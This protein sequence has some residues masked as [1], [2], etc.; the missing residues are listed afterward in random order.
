MK[1][2]PAL[3]LAASLLSLLLTTPAL[4][5]DTAQPAWDQLPA[6]DRELLLQPVRE[7]WN[8][9]DAAQRARML[10]HARRWRDMPP[11]QRARAHVGMRRFDKLTP[12]Q[13]AQMKVLFDKTRGMDRRERRQ[14][15]ALFHAM[16]GMSVQQRD[17][18]RAQWSKMSSQQR[19]DWMRENAPRRGKD[20]G[21]DG[22]RGR[23]GH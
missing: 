17:A 13:Q 23:D 1:K 4:A 19:E 2:A 3:A 9:A 6:A 5:Q 14:A 8:N 10:E 21:H 12:E 18:L 7:R 22:R 15:F 11:E 20:E 16:R